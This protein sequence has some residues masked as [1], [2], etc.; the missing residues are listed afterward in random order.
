MPWQ[1]T[2]TV[3]T[4]SPNHIPIARCGAVVALSLSGA[5]IRKLRNTSRHAKTHHGYNYDPWAP[6]QVLSIQCYPD[7][8]HTMDIHDSTKHYV[9][10]PEAFM[11]TLL[12]E[13]KDAQ[14][15]YEVIYQRITKLV[16]PGVGY[17]SLSLETVS[18]I[19]SSYLFC[20]IKPDLLTV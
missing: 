9:N 15:R 12:A 2:D 4:E 19:Y 1:L 20:L 3:R 11:Y 14:K 13:F 10:G 17:F 8:K 6:W 16:T 7:H 18:P 5:P